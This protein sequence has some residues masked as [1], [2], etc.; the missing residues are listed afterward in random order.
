MVLSR[1]PPDAAG[2][3]MALLVSIASTCSS[4][5]QECGSWTLAANSGPVPRIFTALA[6]DSDRSRAVL[7]GGAPFNTSGSGAFSTLSDTW[8]WDGTAWTQR[9]V[10]GPGIRGQHAMAYD[11]ARSRIVLFGGSSVTDTWEWDGAEWNLRATTGPSAR[12]ATAMAFD[13]VRARCVLFGG[14]GSNGESPQ[15]DTWEW[16]GNLWTLRT[17]SGPAP[18]SRHAMAFDPVRARIVLFGGVQGLVGDNRLF[19]D[20]WE[21][22]GA[23]WRLSSTSGPVP[24]RSHGMAT[25]PEGVQ[26]F[27]GRSYTPT[28]YLLGDT[29]LWNGSTW[30]VRTLAGPSARSNVAMTFDS[31]REK[32]IV[33]GGNVPTGHYVGDL[34][35]LGGSV[36]PP[37]LAVQPLSLVTEPGQ[38][39]VFV[40]AVV[41]Q[42]P[43]T[44]QWRRN[45][46]VLINGG[47]I[48]GAAT[49]TL[50]L[51]PVL[52]ELA[53]NY[54]VEVTNPCGSVLSA[55]ATLTL[56]PCYANCDGSSLTPILSA[57]DFSC[58]INRYAAADVYANCDASTLQPVLSANDFMCFLHRFAAGCS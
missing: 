36:S 9:A 38:S 23:N 14:G 6:F 57:G 4:R 45:G 42:A 50:A 48:A 58:F 30:S 51:N 21:W 46:I 53:G 33:F 31:T 26:L 34:W 27:G 29:W 32:A 28:P 40:V 10:T 24:R 47:S 11:S 7:Y 37:S 2:A 17:S 49:T 20:T 18:R 8:E 35:E 54:D 39:A 52:P 16:D 3:T 41:S 43:V 1:R 13:S 5:A 15:G 22:D 56:L 12:F 44:Y 25:H 55:A 19:G